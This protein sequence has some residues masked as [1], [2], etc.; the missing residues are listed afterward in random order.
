MRSEWV[1]LG[2][3]PSAPHEGGTIS[4]LFEATTIQATAEL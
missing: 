2:A 1:Y 3:R 4:S